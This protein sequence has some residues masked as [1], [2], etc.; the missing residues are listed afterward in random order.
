MATLMS[1]FNEIGG[2]PSSGNPHLLT[3]ILRDEWR[4]DG[5]VVSDWTS[6]AELVP[7]GYAADR[8][9]AGRLALSAGVDI[10]MASGIYGVDLVAAARAGRVPMAVIDRAVRRVLR[11]K[12]RA[13]LFE[14]PYRHSD[15]EREKRAMLT[16]AHRE[17][18]REVARGSIVLLGNRDE[19]LPLS[20]SLGTIAVIGPLADDGDASLG[21][22]AMRGER[23]DVVTVLG[24]IRR[25]LSDQR[26]ADRQSPGRGDTWDAAP[27]APGSGPRRPFLVS[28][29]RR[30]GD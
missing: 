20:T 2:L 16:P 23:R 14:D 15:P 21:P 10:D 13:G 4:F 28:R 9:E 12:E 17:A 22:W 3:G 26:G 30:L 1:S 8:T 5:V 19:V 29:A 6:V 18:A 7:H 24:G 11:I 25:A 27:Q